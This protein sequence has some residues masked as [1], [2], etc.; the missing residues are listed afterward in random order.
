MRYCIILNI[1][2]IADHLNLSSTKNS[3]FSRSNSISK[4]HYDTVY[5]E[6]CDRR[7][8]ASLQIGI[9]QLECIE[10]NKL[11]RPVEMLG[12]RSSTPCL[13][14]NNSMSQCL[15]AVPSPFQPMFK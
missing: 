1:D 7:G 11:H 5:Q 2:S 10:A 12:L 13:A 6:R 14:T 15:V 9:S 3:L 8:K 4:E